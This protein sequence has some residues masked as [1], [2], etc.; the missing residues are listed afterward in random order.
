M[1]VR[2]SSSV[3]SLLL[4]C[5]LGC[6]TT[7]PSM[8]TATGLLSVNVSSGEH[9]AFVDSDGGYHEAGTYYIFKSFTAGDKE[10]DEL[11]FY[12]SPGRCSREGR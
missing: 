2:L 1:R 9:D 6:E 8:D 12:L 3:A 10:V 4:A 7:S 5:A 11:T